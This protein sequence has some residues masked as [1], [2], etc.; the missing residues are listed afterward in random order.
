LGE[1]CEKTGWRI[2]AYGLMGN[3]YHLLVK[4]PEGNLVSGMKWLQRT[5]TQRYNGRHQ[6]RGHLFQGRYK[7]VPVEAEN[8]GCLEVVSTYIH[9]NPARA[10][11]IRLGR[12][13]LKRYRWSSYPWYVGRGCGLPAW[14]ER[15]RVLGALGLGSN[16]HRRYESYLER[17]VLEVGLKA[18]LAAPEANGRPS[19]GVGTRAGRALRSSCVSECG[20]CWWGGSVNLR[21]NWH[22]PSRKRGGHNLAGAVTGPE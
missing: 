22:C 2:H 19:G 20:G 5:Y 1:A 12:D 11:L 3:H 16:G 10:G 6:L 21:R 13:K 8:A 9:L 14:L 18:G 7:S 4:T 17:R 15:K